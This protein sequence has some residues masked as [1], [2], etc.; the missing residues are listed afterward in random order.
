MMSK[1]NKAPRRKPVHQ[2]ASGKIDHKRVRTEV[3]RK[4]RKHFE[5]SSS[6]LAAVIAMLRS[7]K[8]ACIEDLCKAT[9]WQ[10]HSVRGA[11]SGAIKKRRGLAVT[12]ETT[13][14]VRVYRVI[15]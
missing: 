8:G 11:I 1:L 5:P 14:G 6:K 9:G 4:N 13:D 2:K 15:K 10:A 3:A 7:S 12:S